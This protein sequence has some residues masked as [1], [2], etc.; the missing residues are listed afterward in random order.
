MFS[1]LYMDLSDSIILNVIGNEIG[2]AILGQPASLSIKP[3]SIFKHTSLLIR[4]KA[5]VYNEQ[6]QIKY[7]PVRSYCNL[8]L[9]YSY[10]DDNYMLL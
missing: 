6:L 3:T 5:E 8:G 2:E 7:T 4:A 10:R 1:C 9:D